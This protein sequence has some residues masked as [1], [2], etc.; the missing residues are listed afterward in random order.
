M[1]SR[2]AWKMGWTTWT[3]NHEARRAISISADITRYS[4]HWSIFPACQH[5]KSTSTVPVLLREGREVGPVGLILSYL[6][7]LFSCLFGCVLF[8]IQYFVLAARD[9]WCTPPYSLFQSRILLFS[10][11]V[12]NESSCI[13][14][15]NECPERL[16]RVICSYCL[17]MPF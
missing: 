11:I 14:S 17:E 13:Q 1:I 4:L 7:R 10:P 5:L 15:T 3:L 8:W 2:Q 9:L 12:P 16:P 6:N